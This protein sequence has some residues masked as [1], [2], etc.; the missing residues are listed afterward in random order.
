MLE[1]RQVMLKRVTME[2]MMLFWEVERGASEHRTADCT[3]CN[4]PQDQRNRLV[5]ML[6]KISCGCVSSEMQL[7]LLATPPF[8][9]LRLVCTTQLGGRNN[10]NKQNRASADFSTEILLKS[11]AGLFS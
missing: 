9:K 4:Q 7:L 2:L 1:E 6:E 3:G 11:S 10:E 8:C 5:D